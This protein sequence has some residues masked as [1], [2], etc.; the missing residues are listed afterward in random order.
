MATEAEANT[1]TSESG[2]VAGPAIS[3]PSQTKENTENTEKESENQHSSESNT[4]ANQSQTKSVSSSLTGSTTTGQEPRQQ[5]DNTAAN[6]E[7]R[8]SRSRKIAYYYNRV[9]KESTWEIPQGIDPTTIKGYGEQKNVNP[10]EGGAGQIRASHLLVKHIESRRP[11]SWKESRITRTKD[12]ALALI[13]AYRER[14][15]KGETTLAELANTESDC[16][17]SKRGGDLGFFGRG[18]MQPSFEEAAFKLEVDQLSE[19]VWS[20]SG[21]HLI[22]RTQ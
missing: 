5:H 16:S 19:P 13:L 14:I 3:D 10:E 17:S 21:V 1:D 18:Q 15:E 7:V 9:T 4:T 2:T 20:D 22:L 6:W 12:Q 11:S 8:M